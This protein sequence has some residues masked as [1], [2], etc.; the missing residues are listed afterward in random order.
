MDETGGEIRRGPEAFLSRVADRF[1]FG[2]PSFEREAQAR[3]LEKEAVSRRAIGEIKATGFYKGDIKLERYDQL[4][5]KME[6]PPE[7]RRLTEEEYREYGGLGVK[8]TETF[9]NQAEEVF[10]IWR[11]AEPRR[12][13]AHQKEI[14]QEEKEKRQATEAQQKKNSQEQIEYL[15]KVGTKT[16]PKA[17]LLSFYS[18]TFADM[19]EGQKI[20]KG[21]E[22]TFDQVVG[23]LQKTFGVQGFQDV[24]RAWQEATKKE[25][26][27]ITKK[28]SAPPSGEKS[29][30]RKP[31]FD[32]GTKDRLAD[33]VVGRIRRT[34][35]TGEYDNH[36]RFLFEVEQYRFDRA[37]R[38]AREQHLTAVFKGQQT[39]EYKK[40]LNSPILTEEEEGRMRDIKLPPEMREKWGNTLLIL[41]QT[42][43]RRMPEVYQ[44][45]REERLK[46]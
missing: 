39:E 4:R 11:R 31:V 40:R 30:T 25:E 38:Q 29:I 27:I 2:R 8:L 35:S 14:L 18:E 34:G 36:L 32:E 1:G 9:G 42:F 43:G 26:A 7:E 45:W 37:V 19:E 44:A 12:A 28:K 16:A 41:S 20:T 46:R 21:K 22:E 6:V 33:E 15:R 10:Q 23:E 13:E 3:A 24:L 17:D 5:K